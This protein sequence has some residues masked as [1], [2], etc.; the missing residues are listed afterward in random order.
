MASFLPTLYLNK[1]L[2]SVEFNTTKSTEV[3]RTNCRWSVP[4]ITQTNYGTLNMSA[5]K[6]ASHFGPPCIYPWVLVSR[7][8]MVSSLWCALAWCKNPAPQSSCLFC[9]RNMNFDYTTAIVFLKI[10][11]ISTSSSVADNPYRL[12]GAW[13]WGNYPTEIT[14]VLA[15][16]LLAPLNHVRSVQLFVMWSIEKSFVINVMLLQQT[17]YVLR[18][19]N[20]TAGL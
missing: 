16:L 10:P 17:T 9:S 1:T 12:F 8:T 18:L 5:I 13:T 6:V 19:F 15:A 2:Y 3:L 7:K 20:F 4:K 11:D 14:I